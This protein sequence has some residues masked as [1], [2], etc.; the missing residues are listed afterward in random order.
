[1]III[2]MLRIKEKIQTFEVKIEGLLSFCINTTLFRINFYILYILSHYSRELEKS[3][4]FDSFH[5]FSRRSLFTHVK[6]KYSSR[7]RD[8]SVIIRLRG[9]TSSQ[10]GI[11]NYLTPTIGKLHAYFASA[12]SA[13]RKEYAR[14]CL[15][16]FSR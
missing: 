1:M 14:E 12:E 13:K 6:E 11:R 5:I 2:K 9:K 3:R 16:H 4:L 15:R 7:Y 8:I 10:G